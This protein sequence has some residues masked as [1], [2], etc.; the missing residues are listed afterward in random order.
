MPTKQIEE[1]IPR[2]IDNQEISDILNHLSSLVEEVVNY[3]SHVFKWGIE[4]IKGGDENAPVF[5]M[6]RNIFELIDAISILIRNSCIE[7]CKILLRSL[8][9]SFLSFNYLLEKDLK[10]RGIDFLVWNRHKEINSI[11]R[12]NPNDELSIE[13]EKKK[14]KDKIIKDLPTVKVSDIDKMLKD[15]NKMFDL[16]SYKE[17]VA[18]FQNILDRKGKPPRHWFSMRGG[19]NNMYELADHLGFPAQYDILY[20]SWSGLVHGTD[21]M[22]DKFSIEG[23]GEVSF[24]QLRFPLGVPFVSLMAITF[25]L[26]AIRILTQNY[27]PDRS[28]DNAIWYKKEIRDAYMNIPNIKIVGV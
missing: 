10:S 12:F 5:L 21:I 7:P 20:R 15:L 9:E 28:A 11:R 8:F 13:Y 26:S 16:P 23:P 27:I 14:A 2:E 19:P 6:Y 25:G 4:S 3:G 1:F 17:S 18:E 22:K 24:T